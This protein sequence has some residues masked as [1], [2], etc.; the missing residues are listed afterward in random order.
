[1]FFHNISYWTVIV[2][3]VV[4]MAI[5]YV[6]YSPILFGGLWMKS[7]GFTTESLKEKSKAR[8]MAPVWG[9]MVLS[10]FIMAVVVAA[11]FQ[12]LIITSLGGM[13]LL[14]VCVW[15]AFSIHAAIGDYAFGGEPTAAF[16]IKI[17]HELVAIVALC[18][19]IGIWG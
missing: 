6:W 5:G 1:M 14:A 10:T 11:L 3:T 12:S 7:K 18:L 15:A 9:G 19:I 17:G 16:L 8:S 4:V 2:A 13:L